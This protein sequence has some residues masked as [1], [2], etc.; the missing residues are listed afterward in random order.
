[1]DY[2]ECLLK[3]SIL[4]EK[5][6]QIVVKVAKIFKK[7]CQQARATLKLHFILAAY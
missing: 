3:E 6:S 5:F 7:C 4:R 2:N 1:M